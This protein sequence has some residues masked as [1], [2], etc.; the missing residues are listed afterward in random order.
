MAKL[1]DIKVD[2][3]GP[4]LPVARARGCPL[5]DELSYSD[6]DNSSLERLLSHILIPPKLVK[7]TLCQG[8]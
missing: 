1:N 6:N 8:V 7:T 5:K 4:R 3:C 2:S